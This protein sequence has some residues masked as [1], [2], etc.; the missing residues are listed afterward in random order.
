MKKLISGFMLLALLTV[1]CGESKQEKADRIAQEKVDI[2]LKEEIKTLDDA[3]T[4]I[5]ITKKEIEDSAKKL[6]E[7]LNDL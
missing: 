5:E 1:S 3:I 4:E 6:E 2:A 7:L